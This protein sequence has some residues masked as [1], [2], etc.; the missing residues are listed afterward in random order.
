[1]IIVACYLLSKRLFLEKAHIPSL[2]VRNY[3]KQLRNYE[4]GVDTNHLMFHTAM[5]PPNISEFNADSDQVYIFPEM[6]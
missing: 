5:F 3:D 2:V 6:L 1:M 4:K